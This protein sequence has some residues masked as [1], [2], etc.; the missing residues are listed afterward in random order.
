MPSWPS[1]SGAPFG[2]GPLLVCPER[3][4]RRYCEARDNWENHFESP[5][6]AYPLNDY[7]HTCVPCLQTEYLSKVQKDSNGQCKRCNDI[8]WTDDSGIGEYWNSGKCN[9]CNPCSVLDLGPIEMKKFPWE[10]NAAYTTYIN[11]FHDEYDQDQEYRWEDHW[12][13]L[14]VN[15]ACVPLPRRK[16]AWNTTHFLITGEDHYKIPAK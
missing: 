7:W 8:K 2:A 12:R 15:V 4:Q 14:S 6:H 11:A 1:P 5:C 10:L 13:Y 3:T 9:T 16:I